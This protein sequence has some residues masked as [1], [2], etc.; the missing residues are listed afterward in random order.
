V[1]SCFQCRT[2]SKRFNGMVSQAL[3]SSGGYEGVVEEIL[4]SEGR[5]CVDVSR[6]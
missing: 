5:R 4:G 1:Q 2:L 3:S 6:S